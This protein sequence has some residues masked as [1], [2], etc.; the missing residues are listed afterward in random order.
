MRRFIL[1]LIL[2]YLVIPVSVFASCN[3]EGFTVVYVNGIFTEEEDAKIDERFFEYK[4]YSSGGNSDVTFQL[5]YNPSHIAGVGDLGQAVSQ[6]LGSSMSD[7]DL[8]TILMQIHS[9]ITTQKILLVGHS[10]GTFY[11]NE[12]Y[13]YLTTHG[14]PEESI[15]VYNIATPA[16]S[17]SGD[18]K[19][20]TSG[21]DNVIN[22]T[23]DLTRVAGAPQPLEANILI[24]LS[25]DD[26]ED[27]FRGHAFSREYLAKSSGVIIS[28][29]EELLNGLE[30]G[31]SAG[32][33]AP[34]GDRDSAEDVGCYESPTGT[35]SYKMQKFGFAI[36]DPAAIVAVDTIVTTAKTIAA[37]GSLMVSG[38]TAAIDSVSGIFSVTSSTELALE[39]ES[40]T[41]STSTK[42]I[43]ELELPVVPEGA[44]LKERV[45]VAVN[46]ETALETD[47]AEEIVNEEEGHEW[48]KMKASIP[49]PGFGGDGGSSKAL[50]E[51][52][53]NEVVE[54][55]DEEE[56]AEVV[57]PI[58]NNFVVSECA[59]SLSSSGCLLMDTEVTLS[60]SSD[61]ADI[62]HYGIVVNDVVSAT[63][64]ETT[65]GVTLSDN[66]DSVLSVVVYDD[67]GNS[68][69][70]TSQSVEVFSSPVVINEVA[71][72]GTEAESSDEWIELFNL[73]NK[74]INLS[75]WVLSSEDGSPYINLEGYIS[76][77]E[78]YL[79]ERSDDDAVS[80]I[81]ADLVTVFSGVD[82]SFGLSD[83]GERLLL[84]YVSQVGDVAT[85][86]VD[87]TPAI[88]NVSGCGFLKWCG[89]NS[90]TKTTMER[91]SSSVS[92]DVSTNWGSSLGEF[93]LNGEDV[94]NVAIKGTPRQRNSALYLI[95]QSNV[96]NEDKVLTKSGSPY[97][98]V[99]SG[100]TVAD[101]VTLNIESGVVVKFV[102]PN[103][104][105]LIVNGTLIANGTADEPV[106]FTTFA[107][108]EYG[109]DMNGDGDS[110]DPTSGSWKRIVFNSTGS[111]SS[112]SNTI[113]RYGGKWFDGSVKRGMVVVDEAYV[114]FDN[115]VFEYGEKYGLHLNNTDSEVTNS[116]FRFNETDLDSAG[117]YVTGGA[118]VIE[119]NVF[120]DNR[121]GLYAVGAPYCSV[122]SNTFT[123]N[124]AEAVKVF[125]AV[126]SFESNTGSGNALNAIVIEGSITDSD[127][128]TTT[129]LANS[130]PY[131][132]DS[133]VNVV[134]DS[135]LEFTSGVVVKGSGG[136]SGKLTVNDG[137][138]LFYNGSSAS[139]VVFTSIHDDSAENAVDDDF[140]PPSAG[141]WYG[142][143]IEDGG[144]LDMS[145]FTFKYGGGY[146]NFMNGYLGGVEIFGNSV[147]S[148]VSNALFENNF[149]SGLYLEEGSVVVSDSVFRNHTEERLGTA[150]A[151]FLV[152]SQA[153]L[154]DITFLDNDL[155]IQ[156]LGNS[157]VN[158]VNCDTPNVSP[159]DLL[160][161]V[162]PPSPPP[163]GPPGSEG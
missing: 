159:E 84:Q 90:D 66:S 47:D 153:E 30:V 113:I 138:G 5:G 11:T 36:A 111:G 69:T 56:E 80:D 38:V 12:M 95:S 65:A 116:I 34:L 122:S 152:D 60:W 49:Y 157:T 2:I 17:V 119:N 59:H 155:D 71:W 112:F 13:N 6:V 8:K 28:D 3:P 4:F 32:D 140:T 40:G 154:S 107:D 19:Y 162:A 109:G 62:S 160:D 137:G 139:D 10:Q 118:A 136:H 64:T 15:A 106:V 105:S 73:T 147:T 131:L 68:A 74:D 85:S 81:T 83:N 37:V 98:I 134:S 50:S 20:L 45:V 53:E 145:G 129:L 33:L 130:L 76:A 123:D 58:V 149:K 44:F 51:N 67:F 89:G 96:L 70:S 151:I 143:K 148:T 120:E 127:V 102:V 110:T 52:V 79:L 24:P 46:D 23:R 1:A 128:G 124:S 61:S 57:L 99:R 144:V 29:V 39:E 146:I 75:D 126:G 91:I 16:D 142:I 22:I 93:I 48:W 94:N 43:F 25:Y 72:A 133:N 26:K 55:L 114:S 150:S 97:L 88:D 31:G 21:N 27:F 161:D 132:I 121:R 108:D 100:L 82:G 86:T 135:T 87:E 101:G 9:E 115:V 54:E 77:G 7:F 156:S 141:D 104:P 41:D 35:F 14:V 117:V 92:G 125:G 18:G 63:T 103:T 163:L 158:C 42:T 78:Y